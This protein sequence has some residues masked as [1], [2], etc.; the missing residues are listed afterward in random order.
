MPRLLSHLAGPVAF[1][2]MER[3]VVYSALLGEDNFFH[4]R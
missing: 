2:G 1:E 3:S 4:D